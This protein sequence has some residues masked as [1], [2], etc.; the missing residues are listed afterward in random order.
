[1]KKKKIGGLLV[2]LQEMED[3]TLC[4]NSRELDEI[5]FKGILYTWWNGRAGS[6]CIF[7]KL[8]KVFSNA[9]L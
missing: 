1:M 7:K 8:D 4:V 2:T 9:T 5:S 3:F 6:D